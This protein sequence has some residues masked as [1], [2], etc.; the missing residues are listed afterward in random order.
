MKFR[1]LYVTLLAVGFFLLFGCKQKTEKPRYQFDEKEMKQA[2][3][4]AQSTFDEFLKRF[5][6]PQPG[7]EDFNVKVRISDEHG[8]EHFW[9]GELRLDSEPYSGI[10]GHDP[11]IVRN[12]EFGQKYSFRKSEIVDWMYMANGKM[13]G[14]YTLRVMLESM[15]KEE[16]EE[17]KK[18][19]GW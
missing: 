13:Q 11:E 10:I 18:N 7:D 15:P 16:A 8:V 5:K 17:I 19:V 9:V 3:E 14:N 12:V 6:N 2:S 4:T 1:Y